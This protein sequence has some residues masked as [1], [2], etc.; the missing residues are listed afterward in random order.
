MPDEVD[1]TV[2]LTIVGSP[3][4]GLCTIPTREC[5]RRETGVHKS[6]VRAVKDVVQVVVI[7]VDL[8]RGKL[9]LVNNVLARKRADVESFRECTSQRFSFVLR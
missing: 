9:T 5:V 8:G 3:S 6:A 7:V 1:P 2:I 4:H